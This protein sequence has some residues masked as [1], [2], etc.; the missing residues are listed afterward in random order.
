MTAFEPYEDWQENASWLTLVE[1]TR[2]LPTT[3]QVTT[4]RY[5]VCFDE[6]KRRLQD[7]LKANYDYAIHLGQAPGQGRIEL[8]KIGLN[9]SGRE[10]HAETFVPLME[11][12][13]VAFQSSLP[14]GMWAARIRETGIPA[15][16]SYHAGT[17]LCNATLYLSQY[18]ASLH[19]LKT[20]A[21]FVHVPLATSQIVECN[22]NFASMPTTM[23]AAALRLILDEI[24]MLDCA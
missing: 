17:F 14:L 9:V 1:M 6:V 16:V 7:D 20:Q 4:R 12:G 8:E 22:H 5:P 15:E 21:T 11:D 18:F 19:G 10:G 13:P 23:A 2:N 24:A 3:P